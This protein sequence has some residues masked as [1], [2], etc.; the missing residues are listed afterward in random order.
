MN[1]NEKK[2]SGCI[3][4]RVPK[5]LHAELEQA[6]NE[7]N[8]SLNAFINGILSRHMGRREG[9]NGQTKEK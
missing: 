6:A 7:E 4:L 3:S 5:S 2:H 1:N 9:N 8:V